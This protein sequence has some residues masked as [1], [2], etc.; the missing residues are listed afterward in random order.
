MYSKY[1]F[2]RLGFVDKDEIP[3]VIDKYFWAENNLKQKENARFTSF[4]QDSTEKIF[5]IYCGKAVWKV[6]DHYLF[7]NLDEKIYPIPKNRIRKYLGED[8]ICPTSEK[9]KSAEENGN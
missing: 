6:G 2:I 9:R 5:Y 7:Q 8:I 4:L 1:I 3:Y